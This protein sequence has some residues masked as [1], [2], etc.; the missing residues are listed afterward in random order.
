PNAQRVSVVGEFNFWDGRRHPMRLRRENGK[1]DA[2]GAIQRGEVSPQA[3]IGTQVRALGQQPAV[4]I[5]QQRAEPVGIV[6][7]LLVIAPADLQLI[8]ERI[9][10]PR[11]HGAEEAARIV[12][13]QLRQPPAGV[14]QD[15]WLGTGYSVGIS[16]TKNDYQTYTEFSVTNPYF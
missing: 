3:F 14:Q 2:V 9:F 4:D 5:L 1:A 8:A 16:G 6:D 12:A 7:S 13:V 15:N 11:H 10:A